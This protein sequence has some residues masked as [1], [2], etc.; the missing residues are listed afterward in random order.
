MNCQTFQGPVLD[1]RIWGPAIAVFLLYAT[2]S[3]RVEGLPLLE[4]PVVEDALWR[5]SPES[6]GE[7]VGE[8][9]GGRLTIQAYTLEGPF[10]R[11]WV[12]NLSLSWP[13]EAVRAAAAP[14]PSGFW[15]E[16]PAP[17]APRSA[18]PS[19]PRR[20]TDSPEAAPQG[21]PTPPPAASSPPPPAPL[22]PTAQPVVAAA[23]H[24]TATA[25]C[26]PLIRDL[27]VVALR[28][29]GYRATQ[30]RLRSL[31]RRS[32]SSTLLPELRLRGGRTTE[33]LLRLTP[34]EADPTRYVQSGQAGMFFDA[35]LSWRLH[36][37]VFADE[38]LR[39]ETLRDQQ[40]AAEAALLKRVLVSLFAWERARLV[41]R[42]SS[43]SAEDQA[44]AA[45]DQLEA[46]I[47]LDV[48]TDGWFSRHVGGEAV[49]REGD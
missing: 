49:Q 41:R 3:S 39:V 17:E 8:P 47:T 18:P 24:P 40:S 34:T 46:E 43:L 6:V 23:A 28:V 16:G 19:R 12:A 42:N 2:V 21:A 27:L 44:S 37:L 31:S 20:R 1:L 10:G 5:A 26:Y 7:T 13:W 9:P 33:Q 35:T 4:G 45:F 36:R 30:R 38:E 15:G 14:P 32:R 22:P 25:L 29:G 48:M 11:E